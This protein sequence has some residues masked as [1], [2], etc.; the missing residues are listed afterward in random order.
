MNNNNNNNN[1]NNIDI[2]YGNIK[3][4]GQFLTP[5]QTQL[6]PSVNYTSS[7]NELY[8]LILHDPN[9]ATSSKNHIHWLIINIPGSSLHNSNI[10]NGDIL[11]PYK[12]PAPPPNSGIHNYIFE[13]YK[14]PNRL[15]E[16]PMNDNDRVITLNYFKQYRDPL[17]LIVTTKF[18]SRNSSDNTTS[19][20]SRKR[21]RKRKRKINRKTNKRK[22]FIQWSKTRRR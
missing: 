1:N 16:S 5:E 21:K 8:T 3:I 13:L 19:G 9:A 17:N 7:S 18:I 4:N 2:R 10:N 12:G 11:L 15:N 14:Q 20:K 6:Q 22:R